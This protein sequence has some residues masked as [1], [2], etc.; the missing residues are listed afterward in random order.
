MVAPTPRSGSANRWCLSRSTFSA[1]PL[2][3]PALPRSGGCWGAWTWANGWDSPDLLRLSPQP[4]SYAAGMCP[5]V[6]VLS[7]ARVFSEGFPGVHLHLWIRHL[8]VGLCAGFLPAPARNTRPA[9]NTLHPDSSPIAPRRALG[10]SRRC[11]LRL[12]ATH[13]AQSGVRPARDHPLSA[14]PASSS[15]N[16]GVERT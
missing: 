3:T 8:G 4:D 1:A 7:G 16:G 9:R 12:R 6:L 13:S 15:T 2:T 10:S 5:G 14:L 11:D